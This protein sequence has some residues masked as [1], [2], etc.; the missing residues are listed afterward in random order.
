MRRSISVYVSLPMISME[1]FDF[2][3]NYVQIIKELGLKVISEWVC[4][5]PYNEKL[6]PRSIFERDIKAINVSDLLIADIT[7]QSHGVGM[8]IM[9][10]YMLG[11]KLIVTF[12]KG[13][14]VSRMILGIPGI[15]CVEYESLSDLREKLSEAIKRMW[16][17]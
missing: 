7:H 16:A 17:D 3:K 14:K 15:L 5:P 13:S 1:N 12:K 2:H 8:E 9:Y 10:A 4:I 6:P 11:K